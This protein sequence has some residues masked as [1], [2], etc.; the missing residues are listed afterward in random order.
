[1]LAE[2]T[3]GV[4]NVTAEAAWPLLGLMSDAGDIVVGKEPSGVEARY[5]H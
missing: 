3:R 4:I 2:R 5:W 1:M